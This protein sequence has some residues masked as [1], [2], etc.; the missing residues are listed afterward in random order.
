MVE[1]TLKLEHVT[2]ISLETYSFQA[3]DFYKKLGFEEVARID[4]LDEENVKKIFL[5]K[6]IG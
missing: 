4:F 5:K 2:Q 6:H 1:K 3:P